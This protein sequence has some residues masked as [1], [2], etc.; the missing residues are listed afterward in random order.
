M[1]VIVSISA[2]SAADLNHEGDIS[3]A[4]GDNDNLEIDQITQNLQAEDSHNMNLT[5][6]S[7][8][9]D[10]GDDSLDL[11]DSTRQDNNDEN[12]LESSSE[13]GGLSLLGTSDE[14]S[15]LTV[16]STVPTMTINSDKSVIYYGENLTLTIV[17]KGP[18]G[19]DIT[20]TDANPI[21]FDIHDIPPANDPYGQTDFHEW[22]N[23]TGTVFE[24]PAKLSQDNYTVEFKWDG[25]DTY[26]GI[27]QVFNF[28]VLSPKG[29]F[30]ELQELID[31]FDFYLSSVLY[32]SAFTY[33][34]TVDGDRFKQGIIIDKDFSIHGGSVNGNNS[35]R[36]FKI[37]NGANVTI[38]ST[39]LI[40]GSADNGGAIY[41]G[42]NSTFNVLD[43]TMFDS[44]KASNYGGAIYIEE[45]S[46]ANVF[47]SFFKHN[48]AAFNLSS[49]IYN[50]G[51]LY[52]DS[53]AINGQIYENY[54]C[55][56]YNEGNITSKVYVV[57]E[58][59]IGWYYDEFRQD[60]DWEHNRIRTMDDEF[61]FRITFYDGNGTEYRERNLIASPTNLKFYTVDHNG[62]I[63]YDGAMQY[64]NGSIKH[65]DYVA[66]FNQT[67]GKYDA[68]IGLAGKGRK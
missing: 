35:A 36:L 44:N 46:S 25:D 61:P 47:N 64:S 27:S 8:E 48:S 57:V 43:Y 31:H 58:I 63:M 55:S 9:T 10:N 15:V 18:N 16:G 30:S 13:N 32:L 6:L 66:E 41:V 67:T 17:L 60:P 24:V 59:D 21:K 49:A 38:D 52:L 29:T 68:F 39:E 37:I 5:S 33:N 19:E 20:I 65:F 2:V 11:A 50:K 12:K 22:G 28:T 1:L 34:E 4:P 40:N 51:N 14:N 54:N 23:V 42:G 62:N 56:I 26:T 3:E 45:G 7:D 53:N